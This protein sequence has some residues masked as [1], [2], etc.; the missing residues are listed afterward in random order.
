VTELIP[1]VSVYAIFVAPSAVV[2]GALAVWLYR[3]SETDPG[4]ETSTGDVR[5]GQ[6][7]RKRHADLVRPFCLVLAV[8]AVSA[9]AYTIVV[10]EG[11]S[12]LG[13]G[14]VTALF[15]S[16]PW[17]VFALRYVGREYLVTRLRVVLMS[18]LVLVTTAVISTPALPEVSQEL[19]P[20]SIVIVASFLSLG[21]A[22]IVFVASGLVLLTTYRH[23][24]LSLTSGAMAVSPVIFLFF[25]AQLSRPDARA[26]STAALTVAYVALALTTTLAVTRY[27]VLSVRPGTGTL[28]ERRLVEEMDE[29]V[30][31]VGR[32]GEVARANETARELFGPAIGGEPFADVLDCP[33]TGLGERDILER[34]T[35]RGRKLFDPRVSTL[36]DSRDRTLGHTV[37]LL[38]VTH[39][40]IR[41]Q[42]IQV[43][44]RILRHNIRN[45]LDVIRARAEVAT[46]DDRSVEEQ[47]D[48]ILGVAEGLEGLSA[49]ARRIEK[50]IQR[51]RDTE[52]TVDL[53]AVVDRV[54][55]TLPDTPPPGADVTVEVPPVQVR[56][57]EGLFRFA[58]GNLIE[59]AI[60]HNDTPD[61]RVEIRGTATDAGIELVVADDGPGIPESELAVLESG[62]EDPLAHAT[63][64]GLWGANWAVQ[65]LGGDLSLGTSDLGG[66]MARIDLPATRLASGDN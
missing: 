59:N 42:R 28:G 5:S 47:T 60:E 21:I 35:E 26:F 19:V 48:T 44:N 10:V 32:R 37:T 62:R 61:P 57:N 36:T 51:S 22:A 39:R 52:T 20:R 56:L 43:L 33:V 31:V 12:E 3:H 2:M 8:I 7:D 15:V 64:L 34:W 11:A 9:F 24:S 45:D 18:V 41:Q 50:L 27:N 66:A 63:S 29:A 54:I 30:F 14:F 46:D 13:F 1:V 49:D 40:E 58:L 16:V 55:D 25:V 23:G 53:A 4:S 38:D 6:S 17:L 65:T